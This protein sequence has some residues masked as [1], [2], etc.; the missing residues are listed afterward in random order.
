MAQSDE[1][2]KLNFNFYQSNPGSNPTILTISNEMEQTPPQGGDATYMDRII[3]K[4]MQWFIVALNFRGLRVKLIL[5]KIR[6]D[7][8]I[9]L[10]N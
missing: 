4:I 2:Y 1:Q 7:V 8:N 5:G 3:D 9:A 10:D 6:F